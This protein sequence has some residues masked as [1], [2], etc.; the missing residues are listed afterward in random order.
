MANWTIYNHGTD[1]S[2]L[3]GPDTGEIVN[4][5]GNNDRRPQFRGKLVTEGVGSIRCYGPSRSVS[6]R[7]IPLPVPGTAPRSTPRRSRRTS[8]TTSRR[9]PPASVGATSVGS[10]LS[11]GVVPYSREAEATSHSYG[12][13]FVVNIHARKV[14]AA[15]YP[16]TYAY[17]KATRARDQNTLAPAVVNEMRRNG[18]SEAMQQKIRALAPGVFDKEPAADA[19]VDVLIGRLSLVE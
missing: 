14:F 6:S 18:M 16:K 5:F 11:L 10:W 1:S 8:G 4:L 19:P 3:K 2:S 13:T 17:L 9:S 15:A 12:E 7:W